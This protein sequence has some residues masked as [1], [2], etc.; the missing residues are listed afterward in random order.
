MS[1]NGTKITI[2]RS[3]AKE[4]ELQHWL[5]ARLPGA[6]TEVVSHRSTQTRADI[7]VGDCIIECKLILDRDKAHQAYSQARMYA[8]HLGKKQVVLVGQPPVSQSDRTAT[9]NAVRA[10]QT[11]D[12]HLAVY[13][14]SGETL[15]VVGDRRPSPLD[16]LRFNTVPTLAWDK[17]LITVG[18]AAVFAGLG[19]VMYRNPVLGGAIG[20]GIGVV[21]GVT[22]KRFDTF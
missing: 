22:E 3:F 13:W 17:I 21:N 5:A 8:A 15:L 1:W 4:S 10:L 11:T 7:V 6:R 9:I 18:F 20:T 19:H 16:R 14:V 2:N 12:R